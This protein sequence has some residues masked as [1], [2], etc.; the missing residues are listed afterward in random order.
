MTSF[1]QCGKQKNLPNIHHFFPPKVTYLVDEA[2]QRKQTSMN[3][4]FMHR[5]PIRYNICMEREEEVGYILLLCFRPRG[6]SLPIN[7]SLTDLTGG[8]HWSQATNSLHQDFSISPLYGCFLNTAYL[9]CL[10]S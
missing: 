2:P 9:K 3:G 4:C 1:P 6:S 10:A 8:K 5:R 7:K